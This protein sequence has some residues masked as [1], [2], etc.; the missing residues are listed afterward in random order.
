MKRHNMA[1]EQQASYKVKMDIHHYKTK[2]LTD[3]RLLKADDMEDK[4]ICKIFQDMQ[5]FTNR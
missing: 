5:M 4:Y 2:I 1:M 3:F